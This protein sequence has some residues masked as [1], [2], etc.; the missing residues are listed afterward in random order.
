MDKKTPDWV[1][2]VKATHRFHV[3]RL[4]EDKGWTMKKT[5]K[6]LNRA[7]GPISEELMVASWL[8]T[9]S[10]QLEEFDYLH[11]AVEYIRERKHKILT[12]DLPND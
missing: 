12:E 4:R 6:V 7:I 8:R 11:E 9:H 1:E 2:K 10:A 3:S 5:A